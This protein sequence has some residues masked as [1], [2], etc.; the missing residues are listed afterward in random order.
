MTLPDEGTAIV[1][2]GFG[3]NLRRARRREG[4]SQEQLGRRAS[5]H[6]TEI[7][8]PERGGRACRIDTLIRVAGALDVRTEESLGRITW[9]PVPDTRGTF[10]HIPSQSRRPTQEEQSVR[11]RRGRSQ[12]GGIE[13]RRSWQV[14]E[15]SQKARKGRTHPTANSRTPHALSPP[16]RERNGHRVIGSRAW[17]GRASDGRWPRQFS[18]ACFSRLRLFVDLPHRPVP[19]SRAHPA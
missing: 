19:H 16:P 4:F 5:L 14:V 6:R 2:E 13:V 18:L 15:K 11:S 8:L 7:G 10:T 17:R 9:M 12:P 1:A 3:A